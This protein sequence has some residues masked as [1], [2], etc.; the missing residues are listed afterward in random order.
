MTR[1]AYLLNEQGIPCPSIYKAQIYPRFKNGKAKEGKWTAE[2][3]KVMLGNPVY[4]GHL[5]QHK[6]AVISY[7][8]KKLKSVPK[9]SWI[10]VKNCH[11]AI[12]SEENFN[13]VQRLIKLKSAPYS[14]G[15]KKNHLLLGLL[16]CKDCGHRMTFTRTAKEWYCIC[17]NYKRFKGCTRHSCSE[18]ILD[19][20]VLNDLRQAMLSFVD[21]DKSIKRAH[22]EILKKPKVNRT[23]QE[24]D[25]AEKRIAEIKKTIKSIYEDKLKGILCEQDFVDL[26]QNYNKE[27]EILSTKI[28]QLNKKKVIEQ[29]NSCDQRPLKL[30]HGVLGLT[31]IPRNALLQLINKIEI[32]ENGTIDIHYEFRKS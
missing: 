2:T 29:Q 16:Y 27:R 28:V 19:S 25:N 8:V 1:I 21:Q 10:I 30:A 11:E 13:Q 20:H 22:E 15:S 24:L 12:V 26:S 31:D 23:K 7:K 6:Y 17:S 32:S 4:A 18:N 3:I 14:N 5:A 9:D